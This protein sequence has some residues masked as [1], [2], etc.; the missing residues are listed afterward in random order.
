MEGPGRGCRGAVWLL[1]ALAL[2]A[3]AGPHLAEGCMCGFAHPQEQFCRA[4][5]AVL[6]KVIQSNEEDDYSR[7]YEVAVKRTFKG[8]SEARLLVKEAGVLAPHVESLCGV[9]LSE[10]E[11]YLLMGRVYDGQPR[12]TLCDFPTPWRKVTVRQRKG[13]RQQ[14]A[15]S[16][17]CKP[18]D[19]PWWGG[20]SRVEN[21]LIAHSVCTTH[22]RHQRCNWLRGRVLDECLRKAGVANV[23]G[24]HAWWLMRPPDAK[25]ADK[26]GAGLELAEEYDK[27]P[28]HQHKHHHHHHQHHNVTSTAST[29]SEDVDP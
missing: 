1:L 24:E 9:T 17:S 15:A 29:L 25:Q 11:T 27:T 18:R 26:L 8:G 13:L 10:G 2:A 7:R 4:H 22:H 14:Y 5:F 16:C 28:Q 3:G 23:E 21:C 19:C 12:V 6:A 20:S